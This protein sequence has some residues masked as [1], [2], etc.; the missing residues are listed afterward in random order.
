MGIYDSKKKISVKFGFSL[1]QLKYPALV[2]LG[3]VLA[4]IIFIAL[5]GFLQQQPISAYLNPNPLDLAQSQTTSLAVD[6]VNITKENASNAALDIV[7]VASEM[8]VVT[9]EEQKIST[10]EAGGRRQFVFQIRPFNK[11][12]PQAGVPAGDYKIKILF[13]INGKE[14]E[15][16]IALQVKKP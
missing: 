5:Q 2:L 6:V 7:P 4:I 9:P 3:L 13:K 14:F 8:F 15:K 16:E 11:N 1:G 12:N 10:M